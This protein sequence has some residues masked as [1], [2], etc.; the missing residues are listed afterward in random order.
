MSA[1]RTVTVGAPPSWWS[2]TWDRT[3]VELKEF[4]RS[5]EQM[6]FIFFFPMI[7][8]AMFGAIFNTDDLYGTGVSF[9]QYFVAGMIA[10]GMLNTGFQSLAISISIDR[11][12]DVLKRIHAT[13]LPPTAYFVGK[14]LQVLIVSV[15][16]VALL[17]LM[18]V[19]MFGVELPS[20]A[21]HWITFAWVFLLGLATS[22]VWG[23]ATS[24]LL[25]NGKAASAIL[26]PVV[27]V[28][29]FTSGVFFVFTELPTWLQHFAEV[30][31][32]KWLAQ[33]MRAVFLP[34]QFEAAE[35]SG[36][37]QLPM[38]A[39]MLT[40]W[41]VAGLVISMKTFRWLRLEDR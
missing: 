16:Q 27:L 35:A 1:A 8:L 38:V 32:L 14:I 21:Q 40:V 6:I 41:L 29:Q 11:A 37:W 33:G 31:P 20:D 26:T 5:R 17:L 36:S 13:P 39:V 2:M 19:V 18:G 30:F 3:R 12:E 25:R 22:T 9:G 15:V 24:S 23:I 28:L 7:F 10:S 4:L 34:E